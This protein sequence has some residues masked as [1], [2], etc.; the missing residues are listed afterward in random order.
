MAN[1]ELLGGGPVTN[2][3]T[4]RKAISGATAFDVALTNRGRVE[5]DT[6]GLQLPDTFINDGTVQLRNG[7]TLQAGDGTAVFRQSATGRVVIGDEI[8]DLQGNS[9]GTLAASTLQGGSLV[10][11]TSLDTDLRL[12][13]M[14]S[15]E[16]NNGDLTLRGDNSAFGGLSLIHI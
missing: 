3:G 10:V 15:L 16:V 8:D 11:N 12:A 6:G 4:I 9:A 5:I 1:G 2:D 7:G 13:Q 14:Q